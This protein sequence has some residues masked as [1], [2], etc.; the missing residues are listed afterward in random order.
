MPRPKFNKICQRCGI[1]FIVE[2]FEDQK[3]CSKKCFYDRP[4]LSRVYAK[5]DKTP[6]HG[7]WGDCWLYTGTL[8]ECGYGKVRHNGVKRG[9]HSVSYEVNIGPIPKGLE[10]D[11]LCRVRNCVNP[12]HLEPVTHAENMRRSPM[13]GVMQKAK[14]HCPQG[15]PYAGDNL[16]IHKNRRSCKICQRAKKVRWELRHP[17]VK[18][19]QQ[20]RT[21]LRRKERKAALAKRSAGAEG[22]IG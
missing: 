7:P 12:A 16:Y 14:T 4:A 1:A 20:H 11:H 15:H 13:Q 21:Y 19:A 2:R 18:K 5:T 9:A 10:I 17:A 22:D 8:D 6:G 3:F